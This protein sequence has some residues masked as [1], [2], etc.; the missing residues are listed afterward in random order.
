MIVLKGTFEFYPPLEI[1][2]LTRCNFLPKIKLLNPT[3]KFIKT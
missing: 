2:P 3:I 1:T